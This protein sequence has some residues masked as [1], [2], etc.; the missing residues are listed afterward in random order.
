VRIDI[1]AKRWGGPDGGPDGMAVATAFLAWTLCELGHDVHAYTTAPPP[2]WAHRRLEWRP[3]ANI[4]KPDRFDADLVITTV[5]AVWR[6]SATAAAAAGALLRLVYWHHHGDPP[7]GMGGLLAAPPATRPTAGWSR[8]IML[9]P[10][11]WAVEDRGTRGGSEVLVPGIGRAKGGPVSLEVARTCTDLRFHVLPGRGGELDAAPWRAL[12]HA[13]VA[14]GLVPPPEFLA[15][16][17]AVLSPTRA[18]VHP[19]A[20]VEAAVRGIPIV[21]TDLPSTRAAAMGAATYLPWDA[22]SW[23]WVLAL[24]DALVRPVEPIDLPP[25]ALTVAAAIEQ[26][27]ARRAA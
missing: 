11:S 9:P 27:A 22:P 7:D 2:A 14:A 3:R 20:L 16:A 18:E 17:A 5:S 23:K 26:L 19:L 4:D 21:C 24:R 12:P 6:R 1:L 10:S 25:Y 13:T 15:R 8:A